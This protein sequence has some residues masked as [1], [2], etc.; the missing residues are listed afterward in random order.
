MAT[1]SSTTTSSKTAIKALKQKKRLLTPSRLP[2]KQ[3]IMMSRL[4][5]LEHSKRP[6][7][8]K[9]KQLVVS[10]LN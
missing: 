7:L 6:N 8:K 10:T 9:K 5:H 2:V 3:F 4:K 1:L